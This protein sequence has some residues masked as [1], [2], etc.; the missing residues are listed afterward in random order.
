[1][2]DADEGGR[3][4][5]NKPLV[6]LCPIRAKYY[7]EARSLTHI[8]LTTITQEALGSTIFTAAG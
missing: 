7:N 8:Y 4:W 2:L 3:C 1:M 5:M 6:W